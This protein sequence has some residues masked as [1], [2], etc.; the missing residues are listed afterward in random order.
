MKEDFVSISWVSVSLRLRADG[1]E[2]RPRAG[3]TL[4]EVLFAGGRMAGGGNVVEEGRKLDINVLSSSGGREGV[5]P[6][7]EAFK[8]LIRRANREVAPKL[9]H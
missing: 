6:Y 9:S 8:T 7:L 5:M 1:S 3:D 2:P 4:F